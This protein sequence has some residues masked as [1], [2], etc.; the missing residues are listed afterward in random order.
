MID[1]N[2]GS[3]HVSEVVNDMLIP[4]TGWFV[5]D[6]RVEDE[7]A[8]VDEAEVENVVIKN[9]PLAAH[10]TEALVDAIQT[11]TNIVIPESYLR[12]ETDTKFHIVFLVDT[13][14][15]HSPEMVIANILAHD[16]TENEERF[17]IH[18]SFSVQT[19][20][21]RK[22]ALYPQQYKLKREHHV[23]KVHTGAYPHFLFR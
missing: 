16:C 21:I 5:P 9:L 2:N 7:K 14:V 1:T 19:E 23:S 13:T 6:N 17:D 12:I 11:R 10:I 15:F 3:H 8:S 18:F 22:C 20:F 4:P